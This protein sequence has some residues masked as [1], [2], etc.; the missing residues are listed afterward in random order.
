MTALLEVEADLHDYRWFASRIGMSPDWVRRHTA[1]LPHH[2][3][4]EGVQKRIR[5]SEECVAMFKARTL[6]TPRGEMQRTERS[7]GRSRT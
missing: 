1:T 4:G 5:F 7:R 6:V 3:V 2:S